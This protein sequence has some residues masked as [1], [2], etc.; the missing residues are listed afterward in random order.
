MTAALIVKTR[1]AMTRHQKNKLH[2]EDVCSTKKIILNK[3]LNFF[4]VGSLIL[5][6]ESLK[7]K[8]DKK[9]QFFAK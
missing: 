6:N 3:K 5:I 1:L 7:K 8:F 4:K 9:L 2:V